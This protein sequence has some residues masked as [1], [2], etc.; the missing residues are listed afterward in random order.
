MSNWAEKRAE[1]ERKV[2]EAR[3]TIL[4]YEK[5]PRLYRTITDSE[6]TQAKR[7]LIEYSTAI[8]DGNYEANKPADPLA[9]M[10]LAQLKEL[11]EQERSAH[12]G[13]EKTWGDD[14][15]VARPVADTQKLTNLLRIQTRIQK[16]ES[17]EGAS[18]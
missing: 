6:Y 9:E 17:E 3:K 8:H 5:T 16:L 15:F 7:D 10:N 11:Y 18:E 1:L 14:G 13:D 12:V 2:L 4:D